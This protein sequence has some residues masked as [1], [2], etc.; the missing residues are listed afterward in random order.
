MLIKPFILAKTQCDYDSLYRTAKQALG[1]NV[2]KTV[3][4]KGLKKD[5][6]KF[7]A[8]YSE[9]L[10]PDYSH[11]LDMDGLVLDHYMYTL[12]LI[13]DSDTYNELLHYRTLHMFA[14]E[15]LKRGTM[16]AI[17]SGSLRNWRDAVV[18]GCS[19]SA[20]PEIRDIFTDVL[21]L[22]GTEGLSSLWTGYSK[23]SYQNSMIL[24]E[25]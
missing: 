3:D 1:Y 15:S 8:S 19:K 7:Y 23:V 9:I 24:V 22:L 2:N 16:F 10:D 18:D 20:L 21:A 12:G 4:S 25:K 13:L 17:V 5:S 11:T 6:Q 14:Q